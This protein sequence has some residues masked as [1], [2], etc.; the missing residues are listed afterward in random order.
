VEITEAVNE[1]GH[2]LGFKVLAEGVEN[3][4][5]L[6]FLQNIGCNTTKVILKVSHYP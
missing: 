6:D 5:Q 1:L 3:Q 4:M 2:A